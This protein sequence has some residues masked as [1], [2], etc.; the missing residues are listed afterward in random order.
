MRKAPVTVVALAAAAFAMACGAR[1]PD[2]EAQ[3]RGQAEYDLALDAFKRSSMREALAHV[4]ASIQH[5]DQSPDSA[6]LGALVMLVFCADDPNSPDC[7]YGEAEQFARKALEL[8]PQ[9]RDAKNTLGVILIHQKRAV[10]AIA[11]LEPLTQDMVYRSPEK[12]WGNLGWA[13]LEAGRLPEAVL[14]LQ[15]SVA[16]QP[17]F[18]VGH[19]RLGL[20]LEKKK[21]L[22]AAK[23]AYSRALAIKEGD[24]ER[25]QDAWLGRGRV[26][27]ALGERE[28]AA[29]DFERCLELSAT[30]AAGRAC[31]AASR[32]E[33]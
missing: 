10:E 9:M 1:E 6:Y 16:A 30:T 4:R 7:R 27:E 33:R 20:A 25:L 32:R 23:Q 14:A 2:P 18:C 31:A 19:H 17:M 15:R 8:D 12:S 28:E 13:Y 3:K 22:V 5:D 29:H 11:I 26:S 24:C 21:E